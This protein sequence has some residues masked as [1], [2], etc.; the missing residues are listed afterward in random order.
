MRNWNEELERGIGMRNWNA[1]RLVYGQT[2]L[3]SIKLVV[4]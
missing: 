1:T 2:S 4:M 3:I